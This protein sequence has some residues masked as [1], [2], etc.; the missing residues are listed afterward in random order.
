MLLS[1]AMWAGPTKKRYELFTQLVWVFS[2]WIGIY[3][4]Q[5]FKLGC[6]KGIPTGQ[7]PLH[8]PNH[9]YKFSIINW[10]GHVADLVGFLNTEY[11]VKY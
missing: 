3:S 9:D 10:L 5:G 2:L 4:T 8:P 6:Q 1:F 7:F 11:S